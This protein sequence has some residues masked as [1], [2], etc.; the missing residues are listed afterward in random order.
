M[1]LTK[2]YIV[3]VNIKTNNNTIIRKFYQICDKKE[4][5]DNYQINYIQDDIDKTIQDKE[6]YIKQY[7]SFDDLSKAIN[8]SYKLV[9][10]NNILGGV[11]LIMT[12]DA[13]YK[14]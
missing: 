10:K 12:W 8:S 9:T 3:G 4:L 14:E 1:N 2:I 7:P 5:I 6:E 11:I 13:L